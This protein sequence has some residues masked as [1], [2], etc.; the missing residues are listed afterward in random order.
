ML[1]H[2]SN[3]EEHRSYMFYRYL[4][5]G[6]QSYQLFLFMPSY[7]TFPNEDALVRGLP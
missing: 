3:S 7:E 4:F 2:R 5:D 6:T 1:G